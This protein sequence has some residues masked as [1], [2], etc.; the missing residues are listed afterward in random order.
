M[1]LK[2]DFQPREYQKNIAE[3]A[4]KRNTLV[5]LPTGMGK[6]LISVLVAVNRLEKYP[7]SKILITAP[8]RPLNAQHKKSFEKFTTINPEEIVLVTGKINPEDR[9]QI[10]KKAKIIVATPQTIENDVENG[11]LSLADFSFITFDEAH[12]CVKDYAYT[13]IAKKYKEQGKNRL[14]LWRLELKLMRM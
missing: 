10:Y 11:R 1:L 3:I 5:V 9:E 6:T 12:R 7:E 2:N 4:S 14:I 8:T 13:Y